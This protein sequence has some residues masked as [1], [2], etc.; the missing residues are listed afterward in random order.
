MIEPALSPPLTVSLSHHPDAVLVSVGDPNRLADGPLYNRRV[1]GSLDREGIRIARVDLSGRPYPMAVA[2]LRS[3]LALQ[4]PRLVIVDSHALTAAAPL[5]A[6]MKS[7]LGVR[8]V[9]LM[10]ALPSDQ[11]PPWKRPLS[12]YLESRLLQ[13]ADRAVAVSSFLRSRLIASGAAADRVAVIPPGRDGVPTAIGPTNG[14]RGAAFR[15]LCV[16]NWSPDNGIHMVVEAMAQLGPGVHLDLVGEGRDK[17]YARRVF[18]RLRQLGVTERVHVHGP[19]EGGPLARRYASADAFVLPSQS[20]G[21]GTACA[22]AMSFGLPVVAF[23]MGPLPWLVE[24][25]C[26]MLVTPGDVAALAEAMK[27][28]ATQPAL[29]RRMGE[30]AIQRV[31]RLPTWRDSEERFSNLVEGLL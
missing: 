3:A 30:A 16:A 20:Q 22:E 21:F 4:K 24:Q 27:A 26:G 18:N 6:W 23:R 13:A 17:G 9:A 2:A 11:A 5:A 15:F 25:G 7:R 28:M 31:G 14:H 10:H 12:T 19:L 8:L 29:L 1:V